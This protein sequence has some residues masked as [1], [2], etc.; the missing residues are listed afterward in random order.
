MWC[1]VC[2]CQVPLHGENRHNNGRKHMNKLFTKEEKEKERQ[3]RNLIFMKNRKLDEFKIIFPKHASVLSLLD[4]PNA[5]IFNEILSFIYNILLE[6]EFDLEFNDELYSVLIDYLSNL[7]NFD[8]KYINACR[9]IEQNKFINIF[10]YA[11]KYD[12]DE[13]QVKKEIERDYDNFILDSLLTG[14]Q[15]ELAQSM[16]IENYNK[17][18][19]E[20]M[21][22]Y[23]EARQSFNKYI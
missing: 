3:K 13:S 1:D 9:R 16:I 21:D 2:K 12:K 15:A 7:Y 23:D 8:D 11:I 18:I 4:Y 20:Y 14:G 10:I 5:D 6:N 17:S 22:L 19:H